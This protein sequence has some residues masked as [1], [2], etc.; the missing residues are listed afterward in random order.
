MERNF[1]MFREGPI[2]KFGCE[3]KEE[4]VYNI[5]LEDVGAK[6]KDIHLITKN[7][8]LNHAFT[9]LEKQKIVGFDLEEYW[10]QYLCLIQISTYDDI[11]LF[12]SLALW[13]SKEFKTRLSKLF[14]KE[15]PIKIGF[16]ISNDLS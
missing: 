1:G 15:K 8:Q 6:E 7:S 5:R 14:L 12:D 11:F 13:T 9:K 2:K 3:F 16:S 10:G 4:E